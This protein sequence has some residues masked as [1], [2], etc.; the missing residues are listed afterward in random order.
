[1]GYTCPRCGF[2]YVDNMGGTL[3]EALRDW[4]EYVMSNG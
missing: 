1:M 3:A 2:E 4:P